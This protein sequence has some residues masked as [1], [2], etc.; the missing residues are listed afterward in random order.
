M[1]PVM[2]KDVFALAVT[3]GIER[4]DSNKNAILFS[5]DVSRLPPTARPDRAAVF[6]RFEEP[7]RCER[8]IGAPIDSFRTASGI[9][10]GCIDC[11]DAW[12]RRYFDGCV[13]HAMLLVRNICGVKPDTP[14][15]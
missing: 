14:Q 15:R 1:R 10:I 11:I 12:V 6:Q 4:C 5:G 2:I 8:I 9:P 13:G 3:L 7:V